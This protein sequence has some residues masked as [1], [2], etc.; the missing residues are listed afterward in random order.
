MLKCLRICQ[1]H[2][3]CS[4]TSLYSHQQWKIVPLVPYPWQHL[5]SPKIFILATMMCVRWKLIVIL[6]CI[7]LM[8]KDADNVFKC[9]SAIR[10]PS[11]ENALFSFVIQS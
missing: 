5:L 3:Q 11:V 4:C 2:S 7:S 9:F 6:I 8:T 10:E 1:I